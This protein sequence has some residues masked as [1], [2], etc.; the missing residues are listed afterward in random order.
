MV[1]RIT[2]PL[3]STMPN[4]GQNSA[5]ARAPNWHQRAQLTWRMEEYIILVC[6][7]H[8][9]SW[10]AH[11][12]S[13]ASLCHLGMIRSTTTD[14]QGIVKAVLKWAELFWGW[15]Q[16]WLTSHGNDWVDS[17]DSKKHSHLLGES[18][19]FFKF[20]G[21]QSC[22][23]FGNESINFARLQEVNSKPLT[24]QRYTVDTCYEFH[25][26]LILSIC[27]YFT[28][29]MVFKNTTNKVI[30]TTC[31]THNTPSP[32]SLVQLIAPTKLLQTRLHLLWSI[33]E[34]RTFKWHLQLL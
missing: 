16:E 9:W 17:T 33:V 32:K 27:N 10:V 21:C 30:K 13:M 29:L 2:Q 11:W 8:M 34:S 23:F 25:Q 26:F 14:S 24:C 31:N 5:L 19:M 7:P 6:Y 18:T 22:T 4:D 12:S 15:Y 1:L 20:N 3:Y 28:T